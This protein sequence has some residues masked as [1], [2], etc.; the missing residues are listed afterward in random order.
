MALLGF[1][2]GVVVAEFGWGIPLAQQAQDEFRRDTHVTDYGFATEDVRTGGD[3]R[4]Q[5]GILHRRSPGGSCRFCVL[6]TRR[7]MSRKM[8]RDRRI[9]R[10]LTRI[11]LFSSIFRKLIITDEFRATI[12]NFAEIDTFRRR[13]ASTIKLPL[14]PKPLGGLI[15]KHGE[16]LVDVMGRQLALLAHAIRHADA[17]YTIRSHSES[18]RVSCA[19]A[20][21]DLF[22]LAELMLLERRKI[23]RKT[24][25]FRV[26]RE[27]DR[28]RESLH[29][30]G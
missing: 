19:T 24:M 3:A 17:E 25:V 9:G 29:A 5:F 2:L 1:E 18:H 22:R 15:V 23:G 12:I 16:S 20:W 21:A 6:G 27:L 7:A 30:D 11:Q 8:S 4:Q 26:P 28:R 14:T 10:F 13:G